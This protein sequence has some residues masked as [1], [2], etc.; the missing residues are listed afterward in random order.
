[1]LQNKRTISKEE[2][3]KKINLSL[4]ILAVMAVLVTGCPGQKKTE[5]PADNSKVLA[6]VNGDKITEADFQAELAGKPES[7]QK[8][9]STPEGKKMMLDRLVERRLLMQTAKKEGV[10]ENPEIEKRL[11]AY[12]E[13]L[14]IEEL[15]KK[16]VPAPGQMN[17]QQLL[18]YYNQNK[19]RYNLPEMVRVRRIVVSDKNTADKLYKEVKATPAKFEEIAKQ[20]S[21]DEVTKSRGGDMGFVMKSSDAESRMRGIDAASLQRNTLPD[22]IAVKVFAMNKDEIS[23]V[24]P[25]G[26]KFFIY[27]VVEK[28]AAEEK[29]FEQVK[30]QISR[31]MEYEGTQNKW[32]DY[33]DGLKKTA[34]IQ[35]SEGMEVGSSKAPTQ[36]AQPAQPSQPPMEAPKEAPKEPPPQAPNK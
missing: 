2:L 20:S 1:M 19:S 6:T 22:E 12:K 9:A 14:V 33:I 36:P 21:E 16:V 17:D 32:K 10:T 29:S 3:M 4:I 8:M 24:L 31:L 26:V 11:Q 27:Q 25:L 5:K 18:D 28:R 30:D 34:T 35:Y 7:Y 13:R 15:R 23:P